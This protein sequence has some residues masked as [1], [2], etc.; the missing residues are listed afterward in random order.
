[1]PSETS[2]SFSQNLVCPGLGLFHSSFL[3]HVQL[4]P[5][6]WACAGLVTLGSWGRTLGQAC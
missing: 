6:L 1:M 2:L 4:L 3:L 5:S